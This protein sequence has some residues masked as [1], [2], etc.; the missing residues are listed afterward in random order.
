MKVDGFVNKLLDVIEAVL[1][2][3]LGVILITIVALV[4]SGCKTV[5][6]RVEQPVHVIKTV[7]N[8]KVPVCLLPQSQASP[9]DWAV[10]KDDVTKTV[11]MPFSV[12]AQYENLETSAAYREDQLR[13]CYEQIG[14]SIDEL[15]STSTP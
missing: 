5:V 9:D 15:Q 1:I 8:T 6:V 7:Q 4:T 10:I 11:S 13:Q 12:Y 2:V 3:C 14:G